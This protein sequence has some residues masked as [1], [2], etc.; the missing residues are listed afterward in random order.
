[1]KIYSR[2]Y[3]LEKILECSE[4]ELQMAKI[5]K[6]IFG[7][8]VQIP[9][10]EGVRTIVPI[11]S[12]TVLEKLQKNLQKNF[13]SKIPV[14]PAAKGFRKGSSY[15][16]FLEE[17][18]GHEYF[19]R[20][21]IRN[22]FDSISIDMLLEALKPYV[23][24]ERQEIVE[25]SEQTEESEKA[26]E[27]EK[28]E[29]AEEIEESMIQDIADLCTWQGK[30][31]QGFITSPAISNLIFT[32]LDQRIRK[33]ARAYA[34]EMRREVFYTRYADDMLFSSVGFDFK[35]NK[36]FKRM[37]SHILEEKGFA[38]NESKTIYTQREI[39]LS[40]YVIK[41]DVHLSRKKLRN[42]NEVIYQFDSRTSYTKDKFQLKENCIDIKQVLRN[43]NA[44]K[45]KKSDGT[46]IVFR[47]ISSLVHYIAGYRSF[48]I[49]LVR[50]EHGNTGYDKRIE[51]KIKILE[52][53]LDYLSRI[54][55]ES[56]NGGRTN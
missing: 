36:N 44:K 54:L 31:P 12:G 47:D 10:K 37:I 14:S 55:E 19:L 22:F 4:A 17:H 51:K 30:V 25:E 53:I 3:F 42:I 52:K 28:P 11:K 49:Q 56:G 29:A 27:P 8:E 5:Q 1:M 26:D 21:D 16:D 23:Q 24:E 13:F 2:K 40:G 48:L 43:I 18:V 15:V 45:M 32:R 6:N 34:K 38:C 35:K 33:Y 20:L 39:S 46:D 7:E 9:K 41:E 50:T